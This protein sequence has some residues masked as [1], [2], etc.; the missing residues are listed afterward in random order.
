MNKPIKNILS[1]L[2]LALALVVFSPL[3]AA[4]YYVSPNGNDTNDGTSAETAFL[5]PAKAVDAAA[6]GDE[7]VLAEGLYP[8]AGELK[9]S[10]TVTLRGENRDTTILRAAPKKRAVSIS[11][12]G[13]VLSSMTVTDGYSGNSGGNVYMNADSL[14]TNCVL[15]N[16][17]STGNGT[18]GSGIWLSA[19][20]VAD[21]IITNNESV[22]TLYTHTGGAIQ[23]KGAAVAERCLVAFNRSRCFGYATAGAAGVILYDN[24]AIVRDCTIVGNVG[25]GY[26]GIYFQS[27]GSLCTNSIVMDNLTYRNKLSCNTFGGANRFR[28]CVISEGNLSSD[29]FTNDTGVIDFVD[30]AHGDWRPRMTSA[31]YRGGVAPCAGAFARVPTGQPECDFSAVEKKGIAPFEV[32]F[33]AAATNFPSEGLSYSW[34]FGDGSDPVVTDKPSVTHDYTAPGSYD[35]TL[36]VSDGTASATTTYRKEVI[37]VPSVVHVTAVNPASAEPYDSWENAATNL[38]TAIDWATDGC[39]ILV[40]DGAL[41]VRNEKAVFV[42]KG[43]TIRSRS[44]DP[45][46]SAIGRYG[47]NKQFRVLEINHPDAV[48]SGVT[49]ENGYLDAVAEIGGNVRLNKAGG[50]VTNCVIRGGTM[51]NQ[52]SGGA[53]ISV[54]GG[55]LCYSIVSNNFARG[56]S[57]IDHTGAIDLFGGVVESCLVT[58]NRSDG[59]ASLYYPDVAGVNVTGGALRNSTIV[60]N[61]ARTCGGVWVRNSN[62]GS[63]VNCLIAGNFSRQVGVTAENIYGDGKY[64]SYCATPE[65]ITGAGP[66]CV[67]GDILFVNRSKGDFSPAPGSVVIGRGLVEDWMATGR[68]LAGNPRLGDDELV[69]IGAFER[70][71]TGLA[72]SLTADHASG[73]VPLEVRFRAQVTDSTGSLSYDWDFTGDGVVDLSTETGDAEWSYPIPGA[74]S[75][76]VTVTDEGGNVATASLTDPVLAAVAIAYVVPDTA[77]EGSIFP[78]GS[79]ETAATSIHDALAVAGDGT[80]IILRSGRYPIKK[81]IEIT[82]GASIESETGIPEDVVICRGEVAS[83]RLVGLNHPRARLSGVTVSDGRMTW[84]HNG[85]NIHV[86]SLGGT[87]SN[88]II[89]NAA[90][91]GANGVTGAG[92]RL[93]GGLVTHCV[94]TGSV[95]SARGG[96]HTGGILSVHNSAVADTCLVAHNVCSSSGKNTDVCSPVHIVSGTIRNCT[97][98]DNVSSNGY[99]GLFQY[100]WGNQLHLPVVIENCLFA[101][102]TS[103]VTRDHGDLANNDALAKMSY[104]ASDVDPG[105]AYAENCLHGPVPFKNAEKGDY[106]P[107]PP[108]VAIRSALVTD[109]IAAGAVDLLGVPFLRSSGRADIGAYH[110]CDILPLVLIL[111]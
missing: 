36:E 56:Q 47:S 11:A 22:A 75:P 38:Q 83:L 103:H 45:S 42:M 107:V 59:S 97:V 110:G 77:F 46:R 71:S 78:Y 49:V 48:L 76:G 53:G 70:I 32:R 20:I 39:T 69:D 89:R 19:G 26:G 3:G 102:N 72:V 2:C 15:R 86:E 34:N 43:V 87:V 94:I 67:A 6:A 5:T 99:A 4:T 13:A 30:P 31:A 33:I 62:A 105:E 23:I 37:A 111:R 100:N 51:K 96:N 55:L 104:C 85:V 93:D 68:D 101:R 8:L 18:G 44:G 9:L 21:T 60:G 16:G 63:V 17:F 10:K 57:S 88:C 81:R 1:S 24:S 7:I 61:S 29:S 40:D 98:V 58:G 65:E 41:P 27:N 109:E 25:Q 66:G 82:V 64:F 54:Q 92:I 28:N 52:G 84:D 74:Y 106:R 95:F 108:A 35:V 90:L 73:A 79:W 14:V 50:T 91:L 12:A 80:R